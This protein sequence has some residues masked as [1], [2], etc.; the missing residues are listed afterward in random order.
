MII[1]GQRREYDQIAKELDNLIDLR[2]AGEITAEEFTHRKVILVQEKAKANE[3]FRDTD[4]R[5]DS[6]L[7]DVEK[8]LALQSERLQ[9]SNMA[10]YQRKKRF[11]TRLVRTSSFSTKYSASIYLMLS[12]A[13]KQPRRL[14]EKSAIC[15]NR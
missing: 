7:D 3:L 4:G 6:W 10:R 12:S 1:S 14:R 13:S 5:L 11:P 8:Q 9:N 15:S 2:V